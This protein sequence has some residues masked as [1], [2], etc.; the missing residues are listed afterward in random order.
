[1]G[2]WV[3]W[4]VGRVRLVGEAGRMGQVHGLRARSTTTTMTTTTMTTTTT[5]TTTTTSFWGWSVPF[6]YW[7]F[8]GRASS[9]NSWGEFS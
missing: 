7:V 1:M 8:E 6:R 4:H 5:T 9:Q 2:A 3:G